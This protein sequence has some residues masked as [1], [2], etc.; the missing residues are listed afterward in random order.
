MA[1]DDER[2][3]PYSDSDGESTP[4]SEPVMVATGY[5]RRKRLRKMIILGVL[6]LLLA[7][8][9]Y[10]VYYFDANRRLPLP[11][12]APASGGI[13]APQYLYSITGQAPNALS[14]PIGIGI[15]RNG[16]VYV[17]DS[18]AGT[19][20]VFNTTGVFQY[21]FNAIVDSRSKTLKNP[22]HLAL[23]AN[24]NVWVTDRRLM[25]VYVFDQNGRFLRKVVPNGDRGFVWA[26]LGITVDAKGDAYVTD[27]PST[28]VHRVLVLDPTGKVK[29]MFGKAGEVTDAKTGEGDFAFPNGAV[30]SPGSGDARELY[31]SD[32]NNRRIQVF[33]PSGT[34]K[35]LIIS[36]GT[37]RGIVLDSQKRL[38]VVDVLS[39]QVDIFST[40]GEHLAT[41]GGSGV[42]PGQFQYPEDVALDA[43]G[44][45]YISDRANDQ[46][47]VWG[48]PEGDIPGLT[49]FERGQLPWCLGLLPLLLLPLLFRKRRFVVTVDFVEGMVTAERVPA[50]V[51][52][53]WRWIIPEDAHAPLVGRVVDGVDLGQLIEPEPYSRSDAT[54]LAS[55]LG[56]PLERAGLL[57]MA[58]RYKTLCTEDTEVS[59][60]AVLLDIDVYDG[61]A[62]LKRFAEGRRAAR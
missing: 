10:T 8:L 56:I 5:A 22:A 46:V 59:R 38:F 2:I 27:V 4:V 53:R 12:M 13:R 42:G 29:A 50:M 17:V 37:P 60:L 61:A 6:L 58:K 52:R 21:R 45:I 32:S 34:F 18:A 7:L 62:F 44:R 23:D 35:R 25:S 3:E 51:N 48:F 41:F 9:A 11:Q 36:E 55:R 15:G 33:S 26:P 47:Q 20:K 19:I 54:D 49:T 24:D 40:T 39:H 30:V 14:A 57:A 31:I 16:R 43:R 1:S 28:T